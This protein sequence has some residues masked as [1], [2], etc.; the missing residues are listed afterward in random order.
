MI[1]VFITVFYDVD[2]CYDASIIYFIVFSKYVARMEHLSQLVVYPV[3][4]T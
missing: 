1:C 4:R 2:R 3:E